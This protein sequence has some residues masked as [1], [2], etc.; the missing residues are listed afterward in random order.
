MNSDKDNKIDDQQKQINELRSMVLQMQQCSPCSNSASQTYNTTIT[1]GASL[2]QN[3]PNPFNHTT[4]INY[5][6]P[7]Q[8]SSAQIIIIDKT[9]KTIKT[10]NISG[11]GKGSLNVDASMLVSGAYNYSLYIDGKLIG[12]KQMILA[13]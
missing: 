8:F 9:G 2:E 10:V 13:K 11:N 12:T 3:A 4:T 1:G 7:Q 5:N 6:L